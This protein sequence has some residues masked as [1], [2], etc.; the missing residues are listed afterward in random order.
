MKR[1]A[2]LLMLL[3]ASPCQAAD[4][5]RLISDASQTLSVRVYT[6][7]STGVTASMTAGTGSNTQ[8]YVVTDATLVTAGMP[9]ARGNYDY[10]I[11]SSSLSN[12]IASGTMGW[13]TDQ[14]I[15]VIRVGDPVYIDETAAAGLGDTFVEQLFATP[16]EDSGATTVGRALHYLRGAFSSASQFSTNAMANAPSGDAEVSRDAADMIAARVNAHR[17]TFYPNKS[18][19]WVLQRGDSGISVKGGKVLTMGAGEKLKVWIDFAG[20]LGKNEFVETINSLTVDGGT[21][22]IVN[23]S[24][25]ILG[26][27]VYFEL[28]NGTAADEVTV[29]FNVTSTEDQEI[30]AAVCELLVT[31]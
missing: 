14:A 22:T 26:N 29:E 17:G 19:V 5:I 9:T 6:G 4:A 1:F 20:L 25:G 21:A 23:D 3:A 12:I 27:L 31:E 10:I 11:Y 16:T 30:S 2:L 8:R 13:D 15:D 28:E 7:S 24:D 18:Q